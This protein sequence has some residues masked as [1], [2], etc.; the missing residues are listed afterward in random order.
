LEEFLGPRSVRYA[1]IVCVQ[2][3]RHFPRVVPFAVETLY[4]PFDD[5]T[6]PQGSPGL[7]LANVRRVRDE[8]DA[9]IGQWLRELG[10][11]AG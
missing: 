10:P 3:Q 8:T 9:R 2:A 4:W 11:S 7:Q 1:I 6:T 5:P